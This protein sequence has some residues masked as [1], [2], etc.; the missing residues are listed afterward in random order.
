MT[1]PRPEAAG[2]ATPPGAGVTTLLVF[3]MFLP[4]LG[5][6]LS[7][8]G[9]PHL[10]KALDADPADAQLGLA[11]FAGAFGTMHLIYGPLGDRFGRRLLIYAGLVLLVGCSVLCAT[12]T[13]IGTFLIGRAGQGLGAAA[14]PLLTRAIIRD[15]WGMAGAGRMM[16]YMMGAFGVA[17]ASLPIIGGLLTEYFD[18][19]AA[20][21]FAAAA[22]TILLVISVAIL[23]ETRPATAPDR[24][25]PGVLIANYRTLF[26]DIRFT[27]VT[28]CGVMV[29]CA[30][31]QWIA[32][33]PFVLQTV[34]GYSP[35]EFTLIYAGTIAVFVIF[36]ILSGKLSG[37]VGPYR[38]MSVGLTVAA[39][40]GALCLAA[41]LG[42]EMTLFV[43]L[44]PLIVMILGHGFTL[45]QSMAAS[46]AP[47]P[48]LAAT[49]SALY[50]FLQYGFNGALTSVQG[51]LY[52]GTAMPM[53]ALI[54][55]LT[56][57]PLILYLLFRGRLDRALP[58][59]DQ[60]P[61]SDATPDRDSRHA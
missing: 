21:W 28:V 33:S 50:G 20:Y 47:F 45:P 48:H 35:G 61:Q 55:A 34:L 17:A 53:L 12:A 2:A 13:D 52:D 40:G 56:I 10:A 36:S 27:L 3:L 29:S 51:W 58:P 39:T 6:D 8:P 22:G 49:A 7:L 37:R 24:L 19:R 32:G 26:G 30:M 5:V 25:R 44:P 59:A 31:F 11:L 38:L 4:L 42:L 16:G 43:L 46:I 41:G 18:W 54:A 23:P 57:I 1:A 14:G 15:L 60:P 9:N